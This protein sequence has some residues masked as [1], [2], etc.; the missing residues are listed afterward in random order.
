MLSGRRGGERRRSRSPSVGTRH[1]AR[2]I[3]ASVRDAS[4]ARSG[5][6]CTSRPLRDRRRRHRGW[7]NLR[8]QEQPAPGSS[9]WTLRGSPRAT[10]PRGEAWC[11][12]KGRWSRPPSLR[13]SRAR[14][15]LPARRVN[16]IA[17]V[18]RR[19]LASNTL[20]NR[21]PKRA[22]ASSERGPS[23]RRRA[24]GNTVVRH[25][26]RKVRRGFGRAR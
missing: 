2:E 12:R 8:K 24:A 7:A 25:R 5:G 20:G 6:P 22:A 19:R 1:E 3:V 23:P 14:V 11:V 15:W 16:A 26:E 13:G 9:R 21:A 10:A 18:V 17:E 4:F